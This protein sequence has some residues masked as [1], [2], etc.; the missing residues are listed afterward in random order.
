VVLASASPRRKQLLKKL[1]KK[2]AVTVSRIDESKIKAKTPEAFAVKAALAKAMD[3][4][5]RQKNALVIGADT[6]VV[7]GKKV[8]GKPRGKKEAAAMLRSL[9]GRTH[10]VITGLAVIDATSGLLKTAYKTTRV[11]MKR[12]SE[13]TIL[14][15]VKTGQPLDKAGAYGI[16][17]IDQQFGITVKGDYD[18]VVGL[19]VRAL[20]H[21]LSALRLG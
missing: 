13:K 8:L 10:K 14:A 17:E 11:K 12:V 6:V 19:P 18:N 2:F 16:Q 3:V 1:I 5:Q 4:A 15:Y 20:K 21:L 7:L 9:A